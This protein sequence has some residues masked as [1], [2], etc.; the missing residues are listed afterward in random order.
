MLR[1]ECHIRRTLRSTM[2]EPYLYFP[3]HVMSLWSYYCALRYWLANLSHLL[4]IN[5]HVVYGECGEMVVIEENHE[6]DNKCVLHM[7]PFSLLSSLS[8]VIFN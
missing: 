7:A 4:L 8:I 6:H 3:P 2:A 5:I 1:K